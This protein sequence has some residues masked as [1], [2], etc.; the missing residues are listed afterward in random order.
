VRAISTRSS[1]AASRAGPRELADGAPGVQRVA[2]AGVG[3]GDHRHL[4]VLDD[5][6][7]ALDD[8]GE[9]EQA[10]VGIAHAAGDA[11]AGGVDGR[12]AGVAGQPRREPVVDAGGDD[13]PVAGHELPQR[14]G[15]TH[16]QA[17]AAAAPARRPK[18]APDM[19]PVPPG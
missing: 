12:E 2:V 7:H 15:G 17:P 16:A 8:L 3:V 6:G 5:E 14:R 10:E 4:G 13:D 11:A 9:A 18:T 1:P 19:R